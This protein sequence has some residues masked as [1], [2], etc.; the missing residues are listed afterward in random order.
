MIKQIHHIVL[1]WDESEH[2]SP[3]SSKELSSKFWRAYL[4][5]FP[6]GIES[7]ESPTIITTK[8]IMFTKNKVSHFYHD[9]AFIAYRKENKDLAIVKYASTGLIDQKRRLHF[10]LNDLNI[11]RQRNGHPP[12]VSDDASLVIFITSDRGKGMERTLRTIFE[13]K[14]ELKTNFA[15]LIIKKMG[16]ERME[17]HG[18]LIGQ[19][20]QK[21][22]VKSEN[23]A[24]HLDINFT[25]A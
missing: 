23:K 19:E 10:I 8:S 22:F 24:L 3:K 14:E 4:H 16:S 7:Y 1:F 12:L 9:G 21:M 2:V 11:L 25:Y 17:A 15:S 18:T 20:L 5:A 13:R 6:E